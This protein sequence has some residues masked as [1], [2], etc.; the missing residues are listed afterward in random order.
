MTRQKSCDP[1]VFVV[2]DDESVRDS[3]VAMVESMEFP[4]ECFASADEFLRTFEARRRGCLVLDVRMPGMSGVELQER[5]VNDGVRL[6]V[7]MITGHGDIPTWV[8]TVRRGAV[9]FIE[10]PYRPRKLADAIRAAMDL[11]VRQSLASSQA[12]DAEERLLQLTAHE[13]D[14][15]SGI[16]AGKLNK[17]VAEELDISL[18][19]VESRWASIREKL[20]VDSRVGLAQL[21]SRA[22]QSSE[23]S[24]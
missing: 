18:R 10:K 22:D 14:V 3:L 23:A 4:V 21:V 12:K 13:R 16:L 24:R 11:D 15:M 9:D 19:T 2:D 5:L 20:R 6:P 17:V 1:T 7:V 8:R